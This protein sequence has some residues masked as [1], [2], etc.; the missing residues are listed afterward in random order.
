MKYWCPICEAPHARVRDGIPIPLCLQCYTRSMQNP[1]P[2]RTVLAP[3]PAE[4]V[5]L[6]GAYLK[7]LSTASTETVTPVPVA[8][9]P[10]GVTLH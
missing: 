4:D 9:R 5:L 2:L 6:H 3:P 8:S 7:A 10:I 1:A